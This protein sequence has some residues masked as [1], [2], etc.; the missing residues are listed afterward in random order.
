M[1]SPDINDRQSVSVVI[2]AMN[3]ARNIEWV[4]QRIPGF[5][6]QVILVD[7]RSTDDTI[8][9]AR[10][11]RPDIEV[12][13][14]T[15]PGKGSAVRTGLAAA[16]GE[17]VVML[18]A[19]GSMDPLEI[20]AF[21]DA[22]RDGWDVAK[23]SRYLPTGGSTDIS[24]LRAMG[25]ST[26]LRIT[27]H[28]IG[29]RQTD[30]CYGFIAFRRTALS[31]LHLTATGFEIEAQIVARAYLAGLRVTE[32]PSMEL[33]RR[34][35]QSNLHPFRDGTRIL[36]S[37]LRDRFGSESVRREVPSTTHDNWATESLSGETG[38]LT[39]VNPTDGGQLG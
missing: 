36:L 29:C 16:R 22:L 23:G 26:L 33:P 3:E 2:P 9:V 24:T 11:Q 12:L 21:V 6:D 28:L 8:S 32:V 4:L 17:Y 10:S 1:T 34:N 25:N 27:G 20:P 18:D 31:T 37:V 7:G 39:S 14:D 5:V 15:R 13:L 19:D 38:L 35:G 30:F